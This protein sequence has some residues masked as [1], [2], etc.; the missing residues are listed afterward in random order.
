M[1][2]PPCLSPLWAVSLD[3]QPEARP[4]HRAVL[5]L[6]L[7]KEQERSSQREVALAG[8]VP[9]PHPRS[10]LRDMWGQVILYQGSVLS[11][12]GSFSASLASRGQ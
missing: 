4:R 5:S 8:P 2:L 1:E 12:V 3:T 9:A 10:Q 6:Y 7:L 11:I